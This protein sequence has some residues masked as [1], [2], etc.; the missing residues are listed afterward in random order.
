[1]MTIGFII[2][3]QTWKGSAIALNIFKCSLA[4]AL[5][6]FTISIFG[7]SGAA[8]YI[9]PACGML[10]LSS[11]LG[12]V[13]GDVA[14]LRALQLLG[15]RRVILVDSLKPFL[16]SILGYFI[17]GE[18]ISGLGCFG[19]VITICG[20]C[21]VSLESVH[22][23][24]ADIKIKDVETAIS[25]S[26]SIENSGALSPLHIEQQGNSNGDEIYNSISADD[27]ISGAT[28]ASSE[29]I[30][31][32]VND[33]ALSPMH[34]E[35][36]AHSDDTAYQ[37]Y[38]DVSNSAGS[39]WIKM[40]EQLR[41]GYVFAILNVMFDAYGAVLTKQYGV[42]FTLFEINLIRFGFAAASLGTLAGGFRL[43]SIMFRFRNIDSK[44]ASK[45]V[46]S[47]PL[48]PIEHLN[49]AVANNYGEPLT[50]EEIE[51]TLSWY[52]FPNMSRRDWAK[53]AIGVVFVTYTCPSLFNYAL[54]HMKLGLCLTITSLGPIFSIPLVYI[55]KKEKTSLR[56]IA[57][58]MFSFVGVAM[59][60]LSDS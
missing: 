16:A 31:V 29:Y 49:H 33:A 48:G 24:S 5:F 14:W 13:V 55:M 9:S 39:S 38:T 12:I 10:I 18:S 34:I 11:V 22:E 15:A 30:P 41:T 17:L 23:P 45:T 46:T 40:P 42:V 54:F 26:T 6:I 19:M 21:I 60:C 53:I 59:L 35:S 2:W 50:S 36:V 8:L 28:S 52:E 57:G 44:M 32:E 47:P 25:E 37:A 20:V 51:A 56:A 4:G 43:Y 58:S 3:D 1:M 7:N 27:L